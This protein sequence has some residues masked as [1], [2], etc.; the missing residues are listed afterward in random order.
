MYI[1]H[2]TVLIAYISSICALDKSETGVSW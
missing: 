2:T 1:K